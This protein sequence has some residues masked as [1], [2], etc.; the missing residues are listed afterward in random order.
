MWLHYNLAL[1]VKAAYY[2]PFNERAVRVGDA[3]DAVRAAHGYRFL[4]RSS[5]S[6]SSAWK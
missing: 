1:A 3:E 2:V 5:S 4:G 6:H